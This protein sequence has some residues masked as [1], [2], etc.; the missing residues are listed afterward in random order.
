EGLKCYP[1]IDKVPESVD[2]AILC[3][4]ANL[5]ETSLIEC[6]KNNVK[7]AIVFASGYSE[8][9]AKGEQAEAKLKEIADQ[10]N[11]RIIGPNCVGILNTTSGL[12]GT[13]SPGLTNV[14]IGDKQEVGFVTQSGAFG[15][16]TYIAAAQ[17]GLTFNYFVSVGNEV[18]V[19]FSDVVE[20]MLHDDKTKVI[21]GYLEGE[22]N[23]EKFRKIAYEAL[24]KNK[25]IV[26]MKSGR[27]NAGS[28]AASSH[29][30]SLAGQDKIYDSFFKQTGI[31]RAADFDDI[32]TFSHLFLTGR[33]PKGRNTAII[34]SS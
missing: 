25:P 9:G 1:S 34:T 5:V 29:T 19:Q 23:S 14:P 11:I 18:D 24:D 2:L 8:I 26:V 32:I 4:N 15:V 10:Y 22:K 21:S 7:A 33:L 27:S 3:V 28:R 12:M 16:L 31:V 17:N 13:F 20:Y 6:G 30:G